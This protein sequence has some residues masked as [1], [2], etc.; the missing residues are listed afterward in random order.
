MSALARRT[1]GLALLVGARALTAQIGHN[2]TRT[3]YADVTARQTVTVFSGHFRALRDPGGVAPQSAPLAGVRY[4]LRLGGPAHLTG[5]LQTIF[6]ERNVIDPTR[7]AATRRIGTQSATMTAADLGLTLAL[8]GPKSYRRLVPT[9]GIGVGV[10]SNF[11]GADTAGYS[12]GT[13]FAFTGGFGMRYVSRSRWSAHGELTGLMYALSYPPSFFEASSDGTPVVNSSIG[14]NA[15]RL[16]R[17]LTLG[18][19]Y[20]L[21]R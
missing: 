8:T 14:R 17:T 12:F 19:T 10:I 5:R 1:L 2:P 18:V 7:P 20:D 3:P 4:D 16:N 13:K 15:W 21:F 11:A 6:S 9:L